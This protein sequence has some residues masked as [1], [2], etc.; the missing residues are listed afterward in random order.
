MILKNLPFEM[1]FIPLY[2]EVITVSVKLLQLEFLFLINTNTCW[3]ISSICTCKNN[4]VLYFKVQTRYLEPTMTAFPV[5]HVKF[6]L[7]FYGGWGGGQRDSYYWGILILFFF[8][9][10][11]YM[12]T[13]LSVQERDPK[14]HR[15]LGQIYEAEGNTE[16]AF[17][18]YKV[19]TPLTSNVLL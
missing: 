12:Y 16:K 7:Q 1:A 4:V 2:Y 17:G 6:L 8:L 18:C 9:F 5:S 10:C 3:Q 15:F 11:R 13:Y 14:A 19:N